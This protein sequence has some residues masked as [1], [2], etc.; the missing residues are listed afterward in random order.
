M[1]IYHDW[2][3]LITPS[4]VTYAKV[5]DQDG[6]VLFEK[7]DD[8]LTIPKNF[9]YNSLKNFLEKP[10]ALKKEIKHTDLQNQTDVMGSLEINSSNFVV[11]ERV[12]YGLILLIINSFIKTFILWPIMYFFI[13]RILAKPIKNL[14]GKVTKLDIHNLAPIEIQETKRNELTLFK[15]AF[16]GLISNLRKYKNDLKNLLKEREGDIEKLNA[17]TKALEEANIEAEKANVLKDE[18]LSNIGQS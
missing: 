8:K 16:N 13:Y 3:G 18:F 9:F 10:I 14:T 11:F 1:R 2:N 7:N 6:A 15:E 17:Q 4:I 12:K 5:V